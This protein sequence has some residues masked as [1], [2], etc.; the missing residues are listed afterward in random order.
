MA[1]RSS[2]TDRGKSLRLAYSNANGVRGTKEELVQF[3]SEK[4]IDICLLNETHLR[5]GEWFRKANYVCHRNDRPTRGV[6]TAIL[7]RR[8]IDHHAVPILGLQ[9]LEAT[10]VQ[11]NL[12]GRP[13][14]LVAVYIAPDRPTLDDDLSECF[15]G[16]ILVLMAGDLNAKH[17]GWDSRANSRSGELLR[18]YVSTK[19]LHRTWADNPHHRSFQLCKS[20]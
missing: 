1:A 13:I 6:G 17:S 5:D 12:S 7:V 8:G 14:K 20:P 2:R 19:F 9:Q 11:L 4:G 10:A 15:R 3:L 16:N 18:E